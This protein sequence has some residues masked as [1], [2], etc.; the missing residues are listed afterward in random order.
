[1]SSSFAP[2]VSLAVSPYFDF[3]WKIEY[4]FKGSNKPLKGK[5]KSGRACP[6]SS[7]GSRKGCS[8]IITRLAYISLLFVP[9]YLSKYTLNCFLP[10]F[11]HPGKEQT[12]FFILLDLL[13]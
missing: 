7:A 2:S 13:P 10:S 4:S 5:K 8:M 6:E 3:H 11:N 12:I 1:M 9:K